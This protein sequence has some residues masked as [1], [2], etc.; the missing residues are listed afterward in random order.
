MLDAN[1]LEQRALSILEEFAYENACSLLNTITLAT[2]R[3]SVLVEFE[4]ALI[5]MHASKKIELE[6]HGATSASSAR[7]A[8][9]GSVQEIR[10][11]SLYLRFDEISKYWH[12]RNN[13]L[14]A[15]SSPV[16]H[17][18][19]IGLEAARSILDR[20]GYRWWEPKR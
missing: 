10:N 12:F 18:T 7:T 13:P 1:E 3:Q 19:P 2:D 15:A 9:Q 14:N 4:D 11:L 17:L 16:I 5:Q 6:L 8:G 20:R